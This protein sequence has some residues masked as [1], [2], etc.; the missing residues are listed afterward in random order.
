MPQARWGFSFEAMKTAFLL[1]RILPFQDLSRK[2]LQ[3]IARTFRSIDYPKGQEIMRQGDIIKE[4]GLVAEGKILLTMQ[5]SGGEMVRCGN[6]C[7]GDFLVDP[8]LM[9]DGRSIFSACSETPAACHVQALKDYSAMVEAYPQIRE[10]FY[11]RA[12]SQLARALQATNGALSDDLRREDDGRD[13][14]PIPRAVR[15]A[16]LYIDKE[17]MNPL[18]LD[19]VAQVNGMS[20]YHFSRVFKEKTGLT[21]KGYLNKCRIERAKYLM[22]HEEMNVSEAAF[23]VGYNDLAYFSRIF[24]REEGIPPS[25]YRKGLEAAGRENDHNTK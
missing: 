13:S 3:R 20:K 19:L 9:S 21:F 16:M 17:Y 8:G 7:A 6:L 14:L 23:A 10:F 1:S 22:A 4:I 24:Q 2:D 5:R 11:K 25:R 15:K 12:M 18:T